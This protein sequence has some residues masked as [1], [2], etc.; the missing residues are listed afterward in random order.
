M[1]KTTTSSQVHSF[2]SLSYCPDGILHS[3]LNCKNRGVNKLVISGDEE[4]I[5]DSDGSWESESEEDVLMEDKKKV[6]L[7]EE[8]K[9]F[10][11]VSAGAKNTVKS[12]PELTAVIESTL[13]AAHSKIQEIADKWESKM[14]DE[15][16]DT[17]EQF[18]EKFLEEL[19]Q[20]NTRLEEKANEMIAEITEPPSN[21]VP[22]DELGA[23]SEFKLI[24]LSSDDFPNSAFS[25]LF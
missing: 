3:F 10:V 18:H 5:A 24:N 16:K 17:Q 13:E 8:L 9:G 12:E 11:N 20:E 19:D 14:T 7:D 6:D 22:L 23:G 21:D 1:K 4:E 15:E 2:L 25:S